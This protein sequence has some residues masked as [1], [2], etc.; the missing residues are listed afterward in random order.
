MALV[1]IVMA[2]YNYAAFI[3]DAVRSVLN[4]SFPDWELLIVDD[5][6][7]DGSREI[8]SELCRKDPRIRML[9]HPG[10]KNLGLADTVRLGVSLSSGRYIA[11]LES[12][13]RWHSENLSRKI[14]ILD[15]YPE[16]AL[17]DD[18]VE[19]FGESKLFSRYDKYWQI[20]ERFFG[21]RR[22]PADIF[23]DLFYENLIPTFS[24]VMCRADVLKKCSFE[25]IYKP[26]LDRSLWMQICK[27]W[28]FYHINEAL[29]CWRIHSNSCI[30]REKGAYRQGFL[31]KSFSL[32]LPC[33]GNRWWSC[34]FLTALVRFGGINIR[35]ALGNRL[36][37]R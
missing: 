36:K 22:F 5:G 16:V 30:S 6:S 20:R 14:A 2:S 33:Y 1:S 4:Q 26:H 13:D 12:D 9:T 19:L 32:L 29:T 11:F 7:T 3:K 28:K 35:R 24:S 23:T 15:R 34:S 37:G 10:E 8:I 31:R 17:V 25:H 27:N 18:A 21:C